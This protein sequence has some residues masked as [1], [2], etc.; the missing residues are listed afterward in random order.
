MLSVAKQNRLKQQESVPTKIV[1]RIP[2]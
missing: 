2:G 1:F